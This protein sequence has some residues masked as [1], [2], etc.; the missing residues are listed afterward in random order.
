MAVR[1][2]ERVPI[3]RIEEQARPVDFGR[4]LMTL[5]VGLFYLLGFIA[6]K[7]A[8]VLGVGLGWMLAAAKTGWQ[9]AA[10]PAAERRPRGR[11]A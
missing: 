9:D 11:P 7:V 8:L 3:E 5:I 2:L 1:L 10:K 4:L 6:R